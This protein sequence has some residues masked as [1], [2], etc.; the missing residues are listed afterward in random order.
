MKTVDKTHYHFILKE[1]IL[2]SEISRLIW[3]E[4]EEKNLLK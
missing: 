2:R 1:G 4:E 3:K